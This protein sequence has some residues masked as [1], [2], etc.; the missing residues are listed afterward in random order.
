[1]ADEQPANR[2]HGPAIVAF[3]GAQALGDLIMPLLVA[4]SANTDNTETSSP[5]IG[6]TR[7]SV[8]SVSMRSRHSG[9]GHFTGANSALSNQSTGTVIGALGSASTTARTWGMHASTKLSA[10]SPGRN[11]PNSRPFS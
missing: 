7:T 8:G 6:G 1:M 5:N 9:S 11:S 3:L 2:G 10:A 4:A